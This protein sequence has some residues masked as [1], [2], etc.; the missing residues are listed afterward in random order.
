MVATT[1]SFVRNVGKIRYTYQDSGLYGD[2]INHCRMSAWTTALE[3]FDIPREEILDVGCSYGS[4]NE[5]YRQLGFEMLHGIDPNK[6]AIG[7][8]KLVFDTAQ[9]AYSSDLPR[10]FQDVPVAASNG[11]IVHILEDEEERRFLA[12]VRDCL[13]DDGFFLFSVINARHYLT[14]NGREPWTGPNSCTKFIETHEE[15]ARAAGLR[16]E[17]QFGTFIDPW[18]MP[19]L[20]FIVSS[21]HLRERPELYDAFIPLGDIL[22]GESLAPFSEV[23]FVTRKA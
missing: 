4:W 15:L 12:D 7:R 8:A 1:P 6:D 14:P 17:A 23:L 16:I 19:D 18:A 22:R 10:L 9:V 11:V 3:K 5:N 20:Q 21:P 13:C 2:F